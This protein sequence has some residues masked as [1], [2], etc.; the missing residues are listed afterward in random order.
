M[1]HRHWEWS[2]FDESGGLWRERGKGEKERRRKS[3]VR[4]P[5]AGLEGEWEEN[6]DGLKAQQ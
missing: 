5:A 1:T 2:I 6:S 4:K 3:R